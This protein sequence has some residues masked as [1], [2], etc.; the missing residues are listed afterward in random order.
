M[1][2]FHKTV[3]GRYYNTPCFNEETKIQRNKHLS[4]GPTA[5]K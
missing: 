1:F 4:Q 2:N 3:Q 5:E